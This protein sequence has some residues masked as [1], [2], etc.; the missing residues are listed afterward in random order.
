MNKAVSFLN[1]WKENV[2]WVFLY[3]PQIFEK[4]QNKTHFVRILLPEIVKLKF[5]PK[6]PMFHFSSLID[7]E[8]NA[9][10]I[11]WFITEWNRKW[12]KFRHHLLQSVAFKALIV[13]FYFIFRW[14]EHSLMTSIVNFDGKFNQIISRE[15]IIYS[16]SPQC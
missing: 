3:W 9:K 15:I 16:I 13:Q 4:K 10:L 6:M 11:H 14:I 1:H 8:S 5:V 2:S 12:L 7:L